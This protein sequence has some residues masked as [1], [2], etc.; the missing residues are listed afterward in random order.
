MLRKV[1]HF[2]VLEMR[3]YRS[4]TLTGIRLYEWLHIYTY[5]TVATYP[6]VHTP[7]SV[8]QSILL[9]CTPHTCAVLQVYSRLKNTLRVELFDTTGENDVL[10]NQSLV[11]AGYAIKSSEPYASRVSQPQTF[12]L[13][14]LDSK[15]TY[16]NQY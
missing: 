5:I 14:I 2:K 10:I 7:T 16:S 9:V 6:C 1:N 11:A 12:E 13:R 15:Q 3:N 8:W 4:K